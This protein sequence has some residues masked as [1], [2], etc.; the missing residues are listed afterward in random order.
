MQ[1]QFLMIIR[2]SEEKMP[3]TLKLPIDL[4]KQNAEICMVSFVWL[5]E[6]FS[7]QLCKMELKFWAQSMF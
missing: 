5:V 2:W 1:F 3:V 6:Q 7:L 4:E